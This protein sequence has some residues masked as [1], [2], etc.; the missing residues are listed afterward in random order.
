MEELAI[1]IQ[2]RRALFFHVDAQMPNPLPVLDQARNPL[3]LSI[4]ATTA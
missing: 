3:H 2:K 4:K 1:D